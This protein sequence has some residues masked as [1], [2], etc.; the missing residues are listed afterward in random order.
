MTDQSTRARVALRGHTP[1]ALPE[2]TGLATAVG[3]TPL[4]PLARV[5]AGHPEGVRLVA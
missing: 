2:L 5:A 1:A 3:N 4:L